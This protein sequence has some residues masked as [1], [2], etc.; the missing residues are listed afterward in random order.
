MGKLQYI[1]ECEWKEEIKR[2][3]SVQTD[4]PRI[5]FRTENESDLLKGILD[6]SLFGY[7]VVYV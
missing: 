6:G 2:C 3:Q 1:W 4:I 7:A 5:L